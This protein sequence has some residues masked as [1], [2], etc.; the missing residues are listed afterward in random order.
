[1]EKQTDSKLKTDGSSSSISHLPDELEHAGHISP[2][3][4][5]MDTLRHVPDKINWTAYCKVLFSS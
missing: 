5:E 1:M 2:T 4:G 3:E